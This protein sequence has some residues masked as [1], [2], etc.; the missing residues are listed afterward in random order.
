MHRNNDGNPRTEQSSEAAYADNDRW[1]LD[2]AAGQA[3]VSLGL[4][5]RPR[6]H[7]RMDTGAHRDRGDDGRS[8]RLFR[9]L[10]V[11]ADLPQRCQLDTPVRVEDEIT[12]QKENHVYQRTKTNQVHFTTLSS[13]N[14]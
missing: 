2:T 7:G 11:G 4:Q 1:A 5:P 10:A 8:A 14:R 12:D 3:A 9:T 13:R 6:R